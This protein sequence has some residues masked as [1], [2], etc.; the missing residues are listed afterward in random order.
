MAVWNARAG[1]NARCTN[2]RELENYIHP[3]AIIAVFAN[4]PA[5]I[6]DFDDV[7]LMLAEAIHIADPAAPA[8]AAVPAETRK[9]KASRAKRRLNQDCMDK[10]TPALLAQSDPAGEITAF[11][12]DIAARLA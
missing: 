2:K 11:L 8:W 4:F 10:M 7:P 5:V 1:C 9:E 3:S 6:A 12:R